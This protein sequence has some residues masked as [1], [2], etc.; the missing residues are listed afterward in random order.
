MFPFEMLFMKLKHTCANNNNKTKNYRS[1]IFDDDDDDDDSRNVQSDPHTVCVY[2]AQQKKPSWQLIHSQFTIVDD[3]FAKQIVSHD[4]NTLTVELNQIQVSSVLGLVFSL[5][6][7]CVSVWCR[8]V[9][10]FDFIKSKF[11]SIFHSLSWLPV[12]FDLIIFF[13]PSAL[14]IHYWKFISFDNSICHLRAC[15]FFETNA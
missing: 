11:L 12:W 4:E 9:Y 14:L 2:V 6:C 5:E 15:V 13:L 1:P 7:I 3:I 8:F 10:S